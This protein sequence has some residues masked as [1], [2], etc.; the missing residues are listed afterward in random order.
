MERRETY[1]S[2][3]SRLLSAPF[4]DD[5]HLLFFDELPLVVVEHLQSI[6]DLIRHA[7][8]LPEYH[9]SLCL[10]L[11][12]NPRLLGKTQ[13]QTGVD[14]RQRLL[15]GAWVNGRNRSRARGE[16]RFGCLGFCPWT[17]ID[18]LGLDAERR[19]VG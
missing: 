13:A 9:L 2:V 7:Q 11:S 4:R 5:L 14:S 6:R 18:E 10:C 17:M 12:S 1:R 19:L 3:V 16:E 8:Q 15:V